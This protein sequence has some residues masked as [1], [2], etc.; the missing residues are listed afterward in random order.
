M[1]RICF[2]ADITDDAPAATASFTHFVHSNAKAVARRHPTAHDRRAI[3]THD[4]TVIRP[5][6]RCEVERSGAHM[7]LELSRTAEMRE[8][9]RFRVD[10]AA[11][12]EN[13]QATSCPAVSVESGV[14][15]DHQALPQ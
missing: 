6:G 5:A 11:P 9:E 14:N 4:H 13:G 7:R 10:G 1:C 15:V 2:T 12:N 3:R 8:A